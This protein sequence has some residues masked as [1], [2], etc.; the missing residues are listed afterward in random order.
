M[1]VAFLTSLAMPTHAAEKFYFTFEEALASNA[2][3]TIVDPSI[4][5]YWG[6]QS[7]P[8][9]AEISRTD[10]YNR[11]GVSVGPFG[12]SRRH[13]QEAF[14]NNLK[15]M[16][17]DAR[18]RGYDAIV[19]IRFAPGGKPSADPLGFECAPGFVT[20]QVPLISSFAVTREAAR[21]AEAAT[22]D[23]ALNGTTP[24]RPPVKNAVFLTLENV[25]NSPEAKAIAG[26]NIAIHW[27]SRN[28]PV[29]LERFGPVEYS[30]NASV[31][32]LGAEGACK[33]AVLNALKSM[34]DDAKEKVYDSIIRIR[35]VLKDR[36][37]PVD[38]DFECEVGSSSASVKLTATLVSTKKDMP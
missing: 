3:K 2:A 4:K 1:L 37:T 12:G 35:S 28:A 13:C 24:M 31:T 17:R 8:E 5:L 11:R 18:K 10:I 25:L 22:N 23:A 21:R 36:F 7:F 34:V 14:E 15:A 29:Y 20:S 32:K 26:S 38:T 9:L 6:E 33:Q 30:D 16:I 19:N 27:G